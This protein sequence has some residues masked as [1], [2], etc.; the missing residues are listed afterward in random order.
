MG[1]FNPEDE[2][3][4]VDALELSAQEKNRI[5]AD[6]LTH[7]RDLVANGGWLHPMSQP[8]S[9]P[10]VNLKKKTKKKKTKK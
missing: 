5:L 3:C 2:L 10:R 8:A 1:K 7:E 9:R 4:F 6:Y